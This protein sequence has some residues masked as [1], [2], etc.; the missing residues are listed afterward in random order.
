VIPVGARLSPPLTPGPGLHAIFKL[1]IESGMTCVTFGDTIADAAGRERAQ[2]RGTSEG[3]C[4]GPAFRH[5]PPSV[6]VRTRGRCQ[7]GARQ[8]ISFIENSRACLEVLETPNACRR[9]QLGVRRLEVAPAAPQMHALRATP[10]DS[11]NP[12]HARSDVA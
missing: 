4:A 2:A 11:A 10:P 9:W 7:C 8:K 12:H 6:R 1:Q 3:R 5:G